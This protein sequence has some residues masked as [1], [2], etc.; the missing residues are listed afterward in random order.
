MTTAVIVNPYEIQH[1]IQQFKYRR[2]NPS[3]FLT[4]GKKI[5]RLTKKIRKN[6]CH[7]DEKDQEFLTDFAYDLIETEDYN[8]GLFQRFW[9]AIYLLIIKLTG[10]QKEFLF[11]VDAIDDLVDTIFDAIEQKNLDYQEVLSDTLKEVKLNP[12]MGKS[13][14]GKQTNEWLTTLSNQVSTEV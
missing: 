12:E 7:F 4:I 9:S 2:I 10:Q 1:E 6:W 14:D 11:C 5:N 8:F 3:R 13:V